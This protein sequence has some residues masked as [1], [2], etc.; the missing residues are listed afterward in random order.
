[1]DSTQTVAP[2]KVSPDAASVMY[3]LTV[4]RVEVW[5]AAEADTRTAARARKKRGLM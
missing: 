2:I 1:M 5:A 3:P 4:W